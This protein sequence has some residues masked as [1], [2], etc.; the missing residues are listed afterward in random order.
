MAHTN[1]EESTCNSAGPHQIQW[2]ESCETAT[3]DRVNS[4]TGARYT[5]RLVRRYIHI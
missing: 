3:G 5:P 2:N 1:E 4:Q